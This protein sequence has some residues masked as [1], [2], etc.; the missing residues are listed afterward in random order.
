MIYVVSACAACPFYL[1]D[2]GGQCSGRFPELKEV[3]VDPE[4]AKPDWCPVR[5]A[6]LRVTESAS[7]NSGLPAVAVDECEDCPFFFQN[8]KRRC[9][10]ANPKGRPILTDGERPVWCVLRKEVIVIRSS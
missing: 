5:D 8:E 1:S 2:H 6:A 10:I 7:N 4:S 9:N 3:D